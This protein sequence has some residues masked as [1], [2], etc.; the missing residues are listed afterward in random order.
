MDL[1]V[2]RDDLPA[3]RRA[4]PEGRRLARWLTDSIGNHQMRRAAIVLGFYRDGYWLRRFVQDPALSGT[5]E[6]T[7]PQVWQLVGGQY[8]VPPLNCTE[9]PASINW[10]RIVDLL[11]TPGAL[12]DDDLEPGAIGPHL[13][14]LEI[15]ASLAVGHPVDLCHAAR[16]LPPSDW[17]EVVCRIENAADY[18]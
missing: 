10:D 1:D 8:I 7:D 18:V 16:V 12:G 6:P 4:V 14:A 2:D 3:P 17:R 15:A 5:I 13:A 11:R 9:T